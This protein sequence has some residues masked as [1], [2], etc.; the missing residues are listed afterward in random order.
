MPTVECGIDRTRPSSGIALLEVLVACG[1]LVVGLAGV[2]ALL[3]AASLLLSQAATEDRAGALAAN[4]GGDARCRGLAAAELFSQSARAAVFGPGMRELASVAP[5]WFAAAASAEQLRIDPT[6]GFWSE[7]HM[8]YE[9]N[10]GGHLM[11]TFFNGTSGP[12]Q[13]RDKVCWGGVVMQGLQAD[14][15]G[16]AAAAPGAPASLLI[17]TFRRAPDAGNAA[18]AITLYAQ[19]VPYPEKPGKFLPPSGWFAMSPQDL[20]G[21]GSESAAARSG[22]ENDRRQFL[23]GCSWVLLLPSNPGAWPIRPLQVNSSWTLPG[24]GVREDVTRRSSQLMLRI[25]DDLMG[26]DASGDPIIDRYRQFGGGRQE[27]RVVGLANVVRVD[28]YHLTLD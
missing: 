20:N 17:A 22:Q 14:G 7:D 13:F 3:P 5:N 25:P 12:R 2:A 28:Q 26:L 9:P 10:S 8:V 16:M 15:L 23:A 4:A 24:P 1:I 21:V 6:R 18:K 11:N 27:L 19:A